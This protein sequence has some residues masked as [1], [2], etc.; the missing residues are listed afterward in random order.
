MKTVKIVVIV[1]VTA[2]LINFIRGS[3]SWPLPRVLPLL[4]NHQPSFLYDLAGGGALVLLLWWG[5]RRL[6]RRDDEE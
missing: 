6:R 2:A 5:L 3:E 1:I 4:G